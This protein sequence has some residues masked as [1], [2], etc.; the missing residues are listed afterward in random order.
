MV[1]PTFS[2]GLRIR[3]EAFKSLLDYYRYILEE[4]DTGWKK[5]YPHMNETLH[6]LA[7]A[8]QN[9]LDSD[10]AEMS[11]VLDSETD[12]DKVKHKNWGDAEQYYHSAGR[13]IAD[14]KRLGRSRRRKEG[15][16]F[17]RARKAAFSLVT[18]L[19][20]DTKRD[21]I[22]QNYTT[23][24]NYARHADARQKLAT[25]CCSDASFGNVLADICREVKKV[26]GSSEKAL[27]DLGGLCGIEN[28]TVL[29]ECDLKLVM[30]YLIKANDVLVRRGESPRTNLIAL[31]ANLQ[32]HPYS[33]LHSLEENSPHYAWFKKGVYFAYRIA[34]AREVL[35]A[36]K[37]RAELAQAV[38]A[39]DVAEKYE[40]VLAKLEASIMVRGALFQS[41]FLLDAESS[42]KRAAALRLIQDSILA[43]PSS[44]NL[45]NPDDPDM[46]IGDASF[47]FFSRMESPLPF[48]PIKTG[49]RTVLVSEDVQGRL[50]Q[51]L[52]DQLWRAVDLCYEKESFFKSTHL[53]E[54]QEVYRDGA[55]ENLP[56]N[57]IKAAFSAVK[58]FE[59]RGGGTAEDLYSLASVKLEEEMRLDVH[60]AAQMAR[61]VEGGSH[62]PSRYYVV[63]SHQIED[64]ICDG[65]GEIY[66]A[67]EMLHERMDGKGS[68]SSESGGDDGQG[69][70]DSRLVFLDTTTKNGRKIAGLYKKYEKKY[71]RADERADDDKKKKLKGRFSQKVDKRLGGYRE[72]VRSTEYVKK[73]I[74]RMLGEA[75]KIEGELLSYGSELSL[76]ARRC[77]KDASVIQDISGEKYKKQARIFDAQYNTLLYG[78]HYNLVELLKK[79][80]EWNVYHLIPRQIIDAIDL[81]DGLEVMKTLYEDIINL[82]KARLTGA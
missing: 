77:K 20:N 37:T 15:K 73:R 46:A 53:R 8:L 18:T 16:E 54:E 9:F 74:D 60:D 34:K 56:A 14:M 1:N 62:L 11:P 23:I 66:E 38:D 27:K 21:P 82:Q 75:E 5:V 79:A 72:E 7:P 42:K 81:N 4:N 30:E 55:R 61:F 64:L 50:S 13:F 58:E 69:L 36:S 25:I 12:P 65:H 67:F 6:L 52:R 10:L 41:G 45:G 29:R 68:E 22:I 39:K 17:L 78:V 70:F 49:G 48:R 76:A 43:N 57:M 31:G 47:T 33:L 35:S 26:E 3:V 51:E 32:F 59:E 80:R 19:E 44:D 24:K 40:K 28:E 63:L 71:G 2:E